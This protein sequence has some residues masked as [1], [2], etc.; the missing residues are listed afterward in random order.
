MTALV[1]LLALVVW[2]WG[3]H[4]RTRARNLEVLLTYERSANRR[5]RLVITDHHEAT[6]LVLEHMDALERRNYYLE[7]KRFS[8]LRR[9][10]R[11]SSYRALSMWKVTRAL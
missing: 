9:W 3:L 6:A 4:H 5:L 8:I 2:L 11:R 7:S 1:C 10:W